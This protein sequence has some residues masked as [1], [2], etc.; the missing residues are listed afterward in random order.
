MRIQSTQTNFGTLFIPRKQNKREYL[1]N[2]LLDVVNELKVPA[3]FLNEGVEFP[4]VTFGLLDKLT[5]LKMKW[6]DKKE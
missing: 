1:F 4:Q 3:V 6:I 2:E 5:E